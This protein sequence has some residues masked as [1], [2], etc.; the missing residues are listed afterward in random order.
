MAKIT[1][2]KAVVRLPEG[3]FP[4]FRQYVN[5]PLER[6]DEEDVE[7]AQDVRCSLITKRVCF[8]LVRRLA[9]GSV[10]PLPLDSQDWKNMRV[11]E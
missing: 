3:E 4:L 7:I 11:E 6:A 10:A 8:R 1:L 9:D 2:K 5:E